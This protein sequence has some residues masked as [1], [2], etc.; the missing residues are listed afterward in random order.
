MAFWDL[1]CDTVGR[2]GLS[3]REL[4][5]PLGIAGQ[6]GMGDELTGRADRAEPLVVKVVGEAVGPQRHDQTERATGLAAREV[7]EDEIEPIAA[8]LAGP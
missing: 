4:E 8:K 6:P 5:R 2:I 1:A 7:A 3:Q